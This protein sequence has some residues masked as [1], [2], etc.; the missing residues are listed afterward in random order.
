MTEII[1]KRRA[2]FRGQLLHLVMLALLLGLLVMLVDMG[3]CAGNFGG[4]ASETWLG[5]AVL[6]PVVHQVYVWFFWRLEL[7]YKGVSSTCGMQRGFG[8]YAAG[9]G[10]LFISRLLFISILAFSNRWSLPL[11]SALGFA[12]AC[13]L[14][15]P[16]LYLAYSVLR[17]FG[18][19]RAFGLDHFDMHY[20]HM[21][22]VKKGAFRWSGN[23]MYVFGFMILWVPGLFFCSKAALLAAAFNHAYIWVHYYCTELPDIRIIYGKSGDRV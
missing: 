5:M 23:A 19:K 20:R 22:F 3:A 4:L 13:V 2:M 14:L 17:Y 15:V 12:L 1:S 11:D 9:F 7:L 8:L 18:I 10:I 21:P 6:I 16:S